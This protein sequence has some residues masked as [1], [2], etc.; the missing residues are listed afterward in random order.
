MLLLNFLVIFEKDKDKIEIK[1]KP[2]IFEIE[3]GRR[4]SSLL[5]SFPVRNIL[6]NQYMKD[7]ILK[8]S[9]NI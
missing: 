9:F 8:K 1:K 2:P 6:G 3:L 7:L 4:I 5:L